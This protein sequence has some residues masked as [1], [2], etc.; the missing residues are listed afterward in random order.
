MINLRSQKNELSVRDSLLYQTRLSTCLKQS[1]LMK[2][3]LHDEIATYKSH[4]ILLND[5]YMKLTCI[6]VILPNSGCSRISSSQALRSL[7]E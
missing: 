4:F 2:S 3:L 1:V 6:H 5:I 7:F